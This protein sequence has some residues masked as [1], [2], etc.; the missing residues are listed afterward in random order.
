MTRFLLAEMW[1][2]GLGKIDDSATYFRV[3]MSFC[4]SL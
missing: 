4:N 2:H 3:S 1:R